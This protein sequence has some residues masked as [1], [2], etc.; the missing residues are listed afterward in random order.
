M[1]LACGDALGV[2]VETMSVREIKER[3]GYIKELISSPSDHR[4]SEVRNLPAGTTSDDTQLARAIMQAV[5]NSNGHFDMESIV[6]E[7]IREYERS[8]G[9]GWGR[10]TRNA[11]ERLK[12][13]VPWTHS[14]EP[15]GGGNGV[16]MKIAPLG[17][18]SALIEG[19]SAL[20][21]ERAMKIGQMTHGDPAAVV[22]GVVHA[23]VI[24]ELAQKNF[25]GATKFEFIETISQIIKDTA[26]LAE[27]DLG[28]HDKKVSSMWS[29]VL[30]RYNN[31]A[32]DIL[33]GEVAE[34]FGANT[35][36]AFY[37]VDSFGLSYF[38]FIRN[39]L[40]FGTVF[41]A[42][43]VGG[44]TDTNAAVVGSLVGALNGAEVIP[45]HI[46]AGLGARDELERQ[47]EKFIKKVLS[48]G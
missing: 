13:G 12:I 1:A 34:L 2:P 6:A 18:M 10:S 4:F 38:L 29:L 48:R 14:A 39:P 40:S 19:S 8:Y 28:D 17:L 37:S 9:R 11:C 30:N 35:S 31:L 20:L 23:M 27:S 36:R 25:S 47:I 24:K 33:F 26:R 16:M 42:V 32:V 7:H 44:D 21:Y 5:I 3:Y 46:L 45:G 43:N 22:A 15:Q 41:D